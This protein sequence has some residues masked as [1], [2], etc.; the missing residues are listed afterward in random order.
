MVALAWRTLTGT[1]IIWRTRCI[2]SGQAPTPATCKP[3]LD[4]EEELI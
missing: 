3:N 2:R 1:S 4:G